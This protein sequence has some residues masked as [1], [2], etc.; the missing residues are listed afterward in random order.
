M[1]SHITTLLQPTCRTLRPVK[2]LNKLCLKK[3]RLSVG[4]KDIS[5]K[6]RTWKLRFMQKN[7]RKR[8]WKKKKLMRKKRKLKNSQRKKSCKKSLLLKKP[9]KVKFKNLLKKNQV[10]KM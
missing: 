2:K 1:Q 5:K 10:V 8:P 3:E 6:T 4:L 7:R 9:R